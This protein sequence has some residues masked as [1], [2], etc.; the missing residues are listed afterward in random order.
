MMKTN[1]DNCVTEAMNFQQTLDRFVAITGTLPPFRVYEL[2]PAIGKVAIAFK[3]FTKKRFKHE[4]LTDDYHRK[5]CN[6][7][8]CLIL[9]SITTSGDQLLYESQSLDNLII[10]L[11]QIRFNKRKRLTYRYELDKVSSFGHLYRD[12]HL[13]ALD[14]SDTMT[15]K[16]GAML[17]NPIPPSGVN[18]Y[19]KYR[20]AWD[21]VRL[22]K[23]PEHSRLKNDIGWSWWS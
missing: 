3:H 14:S 21:A 9:R 15:L 1:I 7:T 23:P 20:D 4:G 10:E 17:I 16:F 2:H 6:D 22:V 13:Y 8:G 11:D 18:N 19:K 5:F 12:Y